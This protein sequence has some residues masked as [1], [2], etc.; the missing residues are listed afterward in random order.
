MSAA[1]IIAKVTRDAKIEEIKREIGQDFGSGY[2]SDPITK[3]FVE[4]NYDKFPKI[5][6]KSWA[7]YKN[8]AQVNRQKKL[9]EY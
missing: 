5:F 2:P 9:G 7:T 3:K 4:E 6:R 1:S 8:A